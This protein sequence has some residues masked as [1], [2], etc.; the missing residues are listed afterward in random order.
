MRLHRGW[1]RGQKVRG[2]V[3]AERGVLLAG[4]AWVGAAVLLALEIWTLRLRSTAAGSPLSVP[5]LRRR[6]PP[7]ARAR[8]P[9]A[10]S[11]PA[12]GPTSPLAGGC[13]RCVALSADPAARRQGSLLLRVG[14]CPSTGPRL[15]ALCPRRSPP[16]VCPHPR[17]SR[18]APPSLQVFRLCF[19][20]SRCLGL[21]VGVSPC[22][23]SLTV[24]LILCLRGFL[25]G[26][27]TPSLLSRLFRYPSLVFHLFTMYCVSI[28]RS[29]ISHRSPSVHHLSH[30]SFIYHL[31]T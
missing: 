20:H 10:P 22:S 17:P 6:S 18:W 12:P 23:V 30:L 24:S 21:P 28:F 8:D 16:R 7:R 3:R 14:P 1:R 2:S 29:F 26:P 19:C 15:G 4:A 25:V 27:V 13:R 11:T 31:S 9:A 5:R